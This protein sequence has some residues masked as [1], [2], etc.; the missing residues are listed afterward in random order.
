VFHTIG[1]SRAISRESIAAFIMQ[2][3]M[4][5]SMVRKI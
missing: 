3:F 5:W 2:V 1:Y 4:V